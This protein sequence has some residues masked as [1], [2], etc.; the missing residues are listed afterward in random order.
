MWMP[1][2]LPGVLG[3]GL[4]QFV[5]P[6]GRVVA[7]LAG[8]DGL[9]GGGADMGGGGEIRLAD[10]QVDDIPPGGFQLLGA[11]QHLVGPLC[12]Q[13]GYSDENFMG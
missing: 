9:G 11:R 13:M 3:D 2:R 6:A 10:L 4:A 7:C 1:R 5:D 8:L 12:F